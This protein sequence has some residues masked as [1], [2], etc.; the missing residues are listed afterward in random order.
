[1]TTNTYVVT[2]HNYHTGVATLK[3]HYNNLWKS[4]PGDHMITLARWLNMYKICDDDAIK[5]VLSK[6]AQWSNKTIVNRLITET[7]NDYQLL[8]LNILIER[9]ATGDLLISVNPNI[10]SFRNG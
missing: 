5:I 8:G 1:M 4:L 6:N 7:K 3:E 10:E 9:L 2:Y